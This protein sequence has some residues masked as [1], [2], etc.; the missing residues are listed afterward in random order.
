MSR[1]KCHQ[2]KIAVLRDSCIKELENVLFTLDID[3]DKISYN[4]FIV[5]SDDY[6]SLR[7][8]K[9]KLNTS[10]YGFG[11]FHEYNANLIKN[12][13]VKTKWDEI[14]DSFKRLDEISNEM[15][16]LHEMTEKV[17]NM[18]KGMPLYSELHKDI[19]KD[20]NKRIDK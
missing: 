1:D 12:P 19:L 15:K 13:D 10:I 14:Q 3:Y 8:L 5:Y 9:F 6:E 16:K 11:G 17:R 7:T 18:G 20:L 2:L 4:K